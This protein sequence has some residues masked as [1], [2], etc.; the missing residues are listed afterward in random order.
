M[1]IRKSYLSMIRAFPGGAD[2]MS[3]ALAMSR[4]ALENRIYERKGQGLLVD[5]ALQLQSFTGTTFF[6]EA[7]AAASGGSFVKLPDH[8]HLDNE[9]IDR[10]FR[11]LV[12]QLGTFSTHFTA[13]TDDD[14]IT[15]RERA[16][17]Q[18]LADDMHRILAELLALTFK[19][20]CPPAGADGDTA[21]AK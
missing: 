11:E 12:A 1:E 4:T 10:K 3:A 8:G 7:V 2:A 20:F 18:A 17:L 5:T 6:A 9:G 14:V 19:V 13:A 15:K 16:D 21:S